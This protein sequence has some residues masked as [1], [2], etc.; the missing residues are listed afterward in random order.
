MVI[1]PDPMPASGR[2]AVD[3]RLQDFGDVAVLA[4]ALAETSIGLIQLVAD[5]HPLFHAAAGCP[6]IPADLGPLWL[7]S[8]PGTEPLILGDLQA[9]GPLRQR[10]ISTAAPQARFVAGFPLLLSSGHTAGSLWALDPQP[11]QLRAQQVDALQRLA[12]QTARLFEHEWVRGSC[13]SLPVALV[14][15][16]RSGSPLLDLEAFH[17]Q[18]E[19]RLGQ[20]Q[21]PHLALLRCHLRKL[22]RIAAIHG[23]RLAERVVEAFVERLIAALPAGALAARY[24]DSQLLVLLS[25]PDQGEGIAAVADR[26]IVALDAPLVV[27]EQTISV[28]IAIGIAPSG[29]DR[30]L[31]AAALL[32]DASI[33][34]GI[35][36]AGN[37]NNHCFVDPVIRARAEAEVALEE[38]LRLVLH[39]RQLL[40]YVQPLVDLASGAPIGF[41][42]LARWQL[43][44][45]AWIPPDRFVPLAYRAGL[46]A[47]LDLQM[48]AK[49]LAVAQPLARQLPGR[50]MLLSVNISTQV[51]EQRPLR[52]RLLE[53]LAANPLPPHWSLQLEILEDDLRDSNGQGPL[54]Q[55]LL[56]LAER[57][58]TIALDDFGAG[59]SWL[60]RL[61]TLPF[62]SLKVD[63]SFVR[64]I[65]DPERPSNTLLEAVISLS[66]GLGL[67]T[68]AEGIETEAQRRWLLEQGITIGQGYLFARPLAEADAIA[69]L[70]QWRERLV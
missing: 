22:G 34:L 44:S 17:V 19:A 56:E 64:C 51:L 45:G 70:A 41:E 55:F 46:A 6:G 2:L 21:P 5:R 36:R 57:G 7:D 13:R 48:I 26:L 43:A 3:D 50:P 14:H 65:N 33:A 4:R 61:H 53:V 24:G 52:A 67:S 20:P 54:A 58:I 32:A 60:S 40:P 39:E 11:R 9:E 28:G 42:C 66:Q 59:H 16:R 49:G 23:D 68:T 15:P 63:G 18:L 12:R 29:A 25:G 35:A 62:R 1:A 31:S 47:E 30:P 10:A 8:D 37:G 69:Y 27:G 38:Q